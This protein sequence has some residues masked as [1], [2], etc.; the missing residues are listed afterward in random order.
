[1]NSITKSRKA[2]GRFN[3]FFIEMII[4]LLFF[5]VASAIILRSFAAADRAARDSRRLENMTFCARSAAELYSAEGSLPWTAERLFGAGASS[6]SVSEMTL[7]LTE[8]CLYSPSGA[9]LFVTLTETDS[10]GLKSLRISFSDAD[11]GE[12]YGIEAGYFPE[13]EVSE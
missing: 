1:M 5:A 2:G 4:V 9:E 3:L 13:K 6:E 8:E 7:P 11:G 10:G 12:L